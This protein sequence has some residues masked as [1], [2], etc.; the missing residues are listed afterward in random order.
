M[1]SREPK[2]FAGRLRRR[3][4]RV[5]ASAVAVAG[6]TVTRNVDSYRR[7]NNRL[8]SSL[9]PARVPVE[10]A[11][12]PLVPSDPRAARPPARRP[13]QPAQHLVAQPAQMVVLSHGLASSISSKQTTKRTHRLLQLASLSLLAVGILGVM[14]LIPGGS[15]FFIAAIV[16]GVSGVLGLSLTWHQAL[17]VF[18]TSSW[19]TTAL[20]AINLALLATSGGSGIGGWLLWAACSA[21][22]LPAAVL[23][24]TMHLLRVWRSAPDRTLASE[25]NAP[26]VDDQQSSLPT[27]QPAMGLRGVP[28]AAPQ[29]PI[30]P[31]PDTPV[32]ALGD[33]AGAANA[34]HAFS[35]GGELHTEEVARAARMGAAAIKAWPPSNE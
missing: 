2:A 19:V 34:A 23:S 18:T 21:V 15:L 3:R 5:P 10:V 14:P 27:P 22:A 26:L 11:S 31:P 17:V 7:A 20:C 28:H 13:A 1:S 4:F 24:S 9:V 32:S 16:A 35:T 25:Q 30:W 33:V 8:L 12:R 6:A 29:R